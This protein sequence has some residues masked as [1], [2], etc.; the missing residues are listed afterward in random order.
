MSN[1]LRARRSRSRIF[2][3]YRRDDSSGHAGRL[4]DALRNRLGDDR[5]FRDIDTIRPGD[6]FTKVIQDSIA[7]CQALIAI[8]GK[9]WL[10]TSA[11]A[12]RR[13]D[14]PKDFVRREIA[15]GLTQNVRVIPVLVQG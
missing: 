5:V 14:D 8:I 6:D 11:G 3:S 1:G 10:D 9:H 7:S 2:I 12:G 13:L 4:Y 15:A